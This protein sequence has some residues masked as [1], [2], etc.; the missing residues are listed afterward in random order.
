MG[1]DALDEGLALWRKLLVV[2]INRFAHQLHHVG[3]RDGLQMR[4]GVSSRGHLHAIGCPL[5]AASR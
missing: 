2:Q 3:D 1:D 4:Q 5:L